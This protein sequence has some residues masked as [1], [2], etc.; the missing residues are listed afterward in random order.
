M[1]ILAALLVLGAVVTLG[2]WA[3]YFIAGDVRVL[4]DYWYSAFEDAFPIA[5]GW[6]ALCMLAAGIG[7][8]RGSR[9]GTLAGLMAGSALIYLVAMDI[10][11]NV[12][13]G[14]YALLP[15][16]GAMLTETWINSSSLGLGIATLIM[17]WRAATRSSS[18]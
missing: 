5:D 2:Y 11:F 10:T 6:M 18:G 3:N 16:S 17:S 14:L 7:L 12:E 8:W 4:P 15:K 13:H 9:A 1:K